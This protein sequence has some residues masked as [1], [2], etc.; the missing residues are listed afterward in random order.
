MASS[1]PPALIVG[2]RSLGHRATCVQRDVRSLAPAVLAMP[3]DV[4]T[5]GES[6]RKGLRV[7]SGSEQ[8]RPSFPD[9]GTD[10]ALDDR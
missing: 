2:T 5:L 3:V 1:E 6:G 8:A 9:G 10:G 7:V 4:T